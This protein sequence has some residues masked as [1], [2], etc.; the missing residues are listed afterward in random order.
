MGQLWSVDADPNTHGSG[1]LI[2]HSGDSSTC[3]VFANSINVIV[4]VTNAAPD[5]LCPPLGGNHC[6]PQSQGHSGTVFA[7]NNPAHRHG[8]SR[9]CGATTV[10]THQSNVFVGD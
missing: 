10:V 6:N 2:A 5:S 1:G 8:D 3:T 4:G 9:N 7:Y